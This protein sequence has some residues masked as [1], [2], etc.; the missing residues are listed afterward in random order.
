LF[1]V[2]HDA[3]RQT[4]RCSA[5]ILNNLP[6]PLS[7]KNQ[8]SYEASTRQHL[9]KHRAGSVT[10]SLLFSWLAKFGLSTALGRL[11]KDSEAFARCDVSF[12][13]RGNVDGRVVFRVAHVN[14]LDRMCRAVTGTATETFASL[15]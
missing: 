4:N 6:D 9:A 5:H 8:P 11:R 13:G 15:D 12:C 14:S 2:E 1:R 10:L 3:E 7:N